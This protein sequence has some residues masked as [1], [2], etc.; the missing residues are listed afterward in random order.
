MS[1]WIQDLRY[2]LR[3]LART[4]VVSTVAA[5]S[6]AVGIAANAGIFALLDGFLLEPLPYHDQ[7]GLVLVREGRQ[8]D[9]IEEFSGPS[10]ASFRDYQ[11]GVGAF[12]SA[13]L[14]TVDAANLT[15]VDVPEQLSVVTTTPDLFEVLGVAP[16]LGR[17]FRP[18]E[19]TE[20]MGDVVVLEHDF[21][22]RRFLSDPGVLGSTVT[23]DGTTFTIVGVTP[24]SF[25]MIPANVDVFR[26]TDFAERRDDRTGRGFIAFARLAPG[27]TLDRAQ[28]ELDDVWARTAP[29]HPDATRGM[30]VRAI[31]A[32][33]F[34]PG[35]TDRQLVLILTAVSL[36]GLLIAC[37]NVANL[38]LSRA[39]E[40]QKEVAVRTA[41][42][43][44]RV[45]ILRQLLTESVTLGVLA[46]A[47][48]TALAVF[49]VRWIR[50]AMP[51][52]LPASM[53]PRLDPN[54]LIATL[55]VSVLAGVVF[56]VAPA[57]HTVRSDLREALG[58]GS[59]GGTASRGRRRLRNA[60]VVG[61]FAVALALLTGAG[62]LVQA[63][64]SLT[65]ADPGFR[66]EGL[67]T[68]SLT[69]PEDR[70]A[71]PAGL[72]RYEDELLASLE[73]I[74]GA[75]GVSVMSSLPRG[76]GNPSARYTV[77][78]RPVPPESEQARAGLQSVTPS[79]FP[80]LG[81]PIV[82]GR[83]LED[84]DREDGQQ[85]AVVSRGFARTEFGGED[86]LGRSIR[87][88]GEETP[89]VIVGVAAD[90]VQ[91]RIPT[92]GDAGEAIYVPLA[93]RPLRSPSFAVRVAGDPTSLAGDVRRAV[94]AVDPDQPVARV[95][96]LD[97]FVAESLAGPRA[98]SQ[99]LG[100][101]G[102]VALLL[103]ALGIY[104]VMAHAVAQQQREIG[105]RMALG[106]GR[107][108]VVGMVTRGG[109]TLAGVGMLLGLPLAWLMY[110]RAATALD[111]FEAPAG[112]AWAGGVVVALGLV[113]V[114]ATWLPA[115][116]ASGVAPVAAL[117]D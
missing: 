55:V 36:F 91:A 110:S 5:L 34:F 41:L 13:A 40:R 99:F 26:P 88:A 19:G 95:Q 108:A 22:V 49:I 71:G 7:D 74:P 100:A 44:G 117:R 21:W 30:S 102:L 109:L 53:M 58:E 101:M 27:A 105:I 65:S 67:L 81:I 87:L 4:P 106:A 80:V 8:G 98:I 114:V 82:Q 78:G 96:T 28:S 90:V 89:R 107:G 92:P 35:S 93:Q 1:T 15:G 79:Y 116:R 77:E 42:G 43:A 17:G 2:G 23:L 11:E 104:G 16:A 69:A 37:A 103:A 12:A 56:G 62:F 113:A 68:F 3:M 85:V 29:E 75:E 33:D 46:G 14:Y 10:V 61:E 9:V 45:R 97:A 38:L 83:G 24:A 76:R 66:Q 51:A 32:R 57:F 86:P 94:W 25:D 39:E 54:V 72:R 64:H 47:I 60:F 111:V 50:G 73:A 59:R 112:L 6:L 115:R 20:G 52:E 63:F 18:E 70:Y 48:G 84:T 31:G